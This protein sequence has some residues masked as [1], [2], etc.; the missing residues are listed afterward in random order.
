MAR[1]AQRNYLL[2]AP[3]PQQRI[4]RLQQWYCR[5]YEVVGLQRYLPRNQRIDF[6]R[7]G[8]V[9]GRKLR[10]CERPQEG[11]GLRRCVLR[12]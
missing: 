6:A 5:L 9:A 7:R 12:M 2:R 3:G 11:C 10:S 8:E 4:G 1:P